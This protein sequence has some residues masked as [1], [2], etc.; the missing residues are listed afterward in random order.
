MTKSS[1][2]HMPAKYRV[3]KRRWRLAALLAA[4]RRVFASRRGGI[5][6]AVKRRVEQGM[7]V[8]A[9]VVRFGEKMPRG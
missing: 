6:H 3:S 8:S 1:H 5:L 9:F 7:R 4:A 2:Q